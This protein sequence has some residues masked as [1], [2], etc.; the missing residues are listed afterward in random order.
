ML[1]IYLVELAAELETGSQLPTGEYTP[2]DTTQLDSTCSDFNFSTES[3]SSRRELVAN[4]V[5]TADA[6]A[7]ELDS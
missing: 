5:H 7:T 1:R 4:R 3:V 2:P 6:D